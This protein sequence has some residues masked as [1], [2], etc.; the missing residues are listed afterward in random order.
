MLT[1]KLLK[2]AMTLQAT[3]YG[4]GENMCGDIGDPMPCIKG[5]VT[6]SGEI[7]DPNIPS[8]ALPFPTKRVI[9]PMSI[10]ISINN[11][12]CILVRLNDKSNPRWIGRRGL[13]LS[14]AAIK[15]STGEYP[16]KHWGGT[17]K[18]CQKKL[19]K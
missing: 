13:D 11:G 18:L 17:V 5:A 7:F 14:P 3:V 19:K 4:L 9:K 16:D 12:K 10:Y 15:Q 1:I 2:L 8:A 6:S